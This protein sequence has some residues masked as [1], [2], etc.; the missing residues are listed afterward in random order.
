MTC[1]KKSSIEDF[2]KNINIRDKYTSEPA[3]CEKVRN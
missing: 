1:K 3:L 2:V